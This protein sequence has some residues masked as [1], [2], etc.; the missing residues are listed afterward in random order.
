MKK[1]LFQIAAA[2][3]FFTRLPLW[4]VVDIPSESFKRIICFWPLTAWITAG[5]TAMVWMAFSALFPINMAIVLT[6]AI[7]VLLTGGLHEDGLAD[8]FDGFGGGKTKADVL[9][10][11]KDSQ[12]GTYALLGL[13]FYYLLLFNVLLLLPKALIVVF[14]FSA[15]PCAKMLTA[16]MMNFL[17]YARVE[18]ESKL[19][20]LFEKLNYKRIVALLIFGLSPMLLFL[21]IKLWFAVLFPISTILLLYFLSKNKI[22]GYTGDVCGA[23]AL[24]CELSLYFGL[25][26]VQM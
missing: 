14:I 20:T 17:P 18:E 19:Q 3:T 5:I 13:I 1:V 11:M 4:R 24:L 15:D 21:N 12:V 8:F 6:F 26:V 2:I 22:G 9:R 16:I 25:V 10:I 7:R 23:S